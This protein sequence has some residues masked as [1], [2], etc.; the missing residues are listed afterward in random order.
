[1]NVVLEFNSKT[2]SIE[3]GLIF[4]SVPNTNSE[5]LE[6]DVLVIRNTF[7]VLLLTF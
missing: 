1:M 6:C 5:N 2:L 7:M 4:Q 3:L